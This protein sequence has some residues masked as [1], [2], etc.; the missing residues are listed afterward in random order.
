MTH[1]AADYF[2]FVVRSAIKAKAE[3]ISAPTEL[4][5]K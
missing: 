4:A 5:A 2:I 1:D 3:P